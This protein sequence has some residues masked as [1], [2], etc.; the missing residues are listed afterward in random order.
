MATL[1]QID[2]AIEEALDIALAEQIDPVTGEI[3]NGNFEQF[4]RLSAA[5]DEK[6]ENIGAYIK[7]LTAEAEA[8]KVEE[9]NLKQRRQAT[10]KRIERLKG[11]VAD[12]M[13]NAGQSK[14]ESPKAACSF[15]KSTKVDVID[16]EA[17]PA[18]YIKITV[19]KSANK[20][21]IGKLLKAGQE[22][23]GCVL[24]ENNN[25]QIK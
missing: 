20:T 22:V 16:L 11:Y 17:I 18:E 7:N 24:L 13:Q 4:E 2:R 14:F 9:N 8:I 21:E 19:E 5:R 6:L 1:Y 15:R 23:P 10:E 25:L 3:L 12:S